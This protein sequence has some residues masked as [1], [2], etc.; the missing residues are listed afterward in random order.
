MQNNVDD[1]YTKIR[2]DAPTSPLLKQLDLT[3]AWVGD[4]SVTLRIHITFR[5]PPRVDIDDL[6]KLLMIRPFI[7][8]YVA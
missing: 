7:A 1:P 3:S 2:N 6:E 4:M 5:K 8:G